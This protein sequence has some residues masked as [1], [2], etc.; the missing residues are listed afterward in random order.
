MTDLTDKIAAKATAA[1]RLTPQ[2]QYDFQ[3]LEVT[4]K[5][6]VATFIEVGTAL[7]EIRDRKLYRTAFARFEDYCRERWNF[8]ASRARQLIGAAAIAASVTAVTVPSERHARELAPLKDD[9]TAMQ[10]AM[11]KAEATAAAEG[12]TVT[13]KDVR[14]VVR[15]ATDPDDIPGFREGDS[16]R[17][18]QTVD[19][20][21]DG[22]APR[23]TETYTSETM[24]GLKRYWGRATKKERKAFMEWVR[25]ED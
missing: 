7:C 25:D 22:R 5:N 23:S 6:G 12:R 20:S 1:A 9:P 17:A 3:R 2:E 18:P 24:A 10:D 21:D 13:A 16:G 15:P 19:P 8:N 11:R 14:A 4:I